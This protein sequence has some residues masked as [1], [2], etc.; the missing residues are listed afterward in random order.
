M[1]KEWVSVDGEGTCNMLY[2][3]N[4]KFIDKLSRYVFKINNKYLVES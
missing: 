2:N 1:Q 3:M 4:I